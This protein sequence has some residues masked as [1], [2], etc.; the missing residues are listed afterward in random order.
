MAKDKP[1]LVR[2]ASILTQLQAKRTITAR[3]IA[4]KYGVSIRTI[5]RDIRTLEESG[6]P[7]I[8]DEGRGYSIM[9]GYRLPPI[10]FTEDEANA[11]VTAEQIINKNEDLSLSNQYQN[12]VTKVKSVLKNTQKE[13]VELL[14]DRLQVRS[15]Q[16]ELRTSNFLIRI[17]SAI[18]NYQ[19]VHIN[20]LS[21]EGHQSQRDIEPFAFY[22][23]NEKWILVAYCRTK[24]DFRAFRLDCMVEIKIT[25]IRFQPHKITLSEYFDKCR[26]K[27]EVP[28]TYV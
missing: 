18:T 13:K 20:Y 28:L 27:W 17:Q 3:S 16:K 10:M 8:A 9:E 2:L 21:L 11:L 22:S 23:T 15:N 19:V 5:Y 1:R 25:S 12:I 4:E 14:E 24:K 7:I 26:K 6:V